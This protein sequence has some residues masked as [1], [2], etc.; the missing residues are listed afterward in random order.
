MKKFLSW[1]L[2]MLIWAGA[3]GLSWWLVHILHNN[4]WFVFF[5]AFAIAF[6]IGNI[7]CHFLGIE[8]FSDRDDE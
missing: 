1:L 7:I 5:I 3:S 8:L 6:F 4:S 2:F